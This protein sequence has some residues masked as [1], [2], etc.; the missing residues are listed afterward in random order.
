MPEPARITCECG[1]MFVT[2]DGFALCVDCRAYADAVRN[3]P[4][5]E[6][7]PKYLKPRKGWLRPGPWKP[8]DES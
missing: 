1:T 2:E 7:K 5:P 6:V 3:L 8:E 4:V